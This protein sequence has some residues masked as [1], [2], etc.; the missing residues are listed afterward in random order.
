MEAMITITIRINTK[1]LQLGSHAKFT[2]TGCGPANDL[3]AMKFWLTD[4]FG[5]IYFFPV[6]THRLL[7]QQ[8]S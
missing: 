6:Q 3:N 5:L 2:A 8:E 4:E 1:F 7:R